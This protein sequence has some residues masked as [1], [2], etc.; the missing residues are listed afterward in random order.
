MPGS[1]VVITH[2]QRDAHWRLTEP[3]QRLCIDLESMWNDYAQSVSRFVVLLRTDAERR[4][5]TLEAWRARRWTVQEVTFQRVPG[6][7]P[8]NIITASLS[9]TGTTATGMASP[10][11]S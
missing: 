6:S 10:P 9:A 7:T 2:G 3:E 4:Q 1:G 11:N 8:G 5:Q